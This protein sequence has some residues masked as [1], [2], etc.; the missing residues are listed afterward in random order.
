[1]ELNT[2]KQKRIDEFVKSAGNAGVLSWIEELKKQENTAEV[3]L[4]GGAVRDALCGFGSKDF[5][6]VVVGVSAKKLEKF[7]QKLGWVELLGKNFGVFKFVP[8]KLKGKIE[9]I[10]IALPRKEHVVVGSGAYKDFKV[11]SDHRLKI[12]DDLSRRD[13]TINAMA[14]RVVGEVYELIDNYDGLNDLE[15]KIIR[16]VGKAKD[17]FAEDYSRMLRAIRFSCQLGFEIESK[18]KKAIIKHIKDINKKSGSEYIIPRE[19]IAKEFIKALLESP[20]KA[21]DLFDELGVFTQLIPEIEA[22]KKCKQPK[23]YHTEGNVFVHTR[24]ALS[25]MSTKMYDN[26]FKKSTTGQ[27]VGYKDKVYDSDIV[28]AVLLHDIDKPTAFEWRVKKGKKKMTYYNHEEMGAKTAALICER[29]KLSSPDKI[30]CRCENV[31]WLIE[32]HMMLLED[33][34]ENMRQTK[35]EKYMLSDRYPGEKLLQ[36]TYADAVATVPA[37]EKI[38]TKK[39][40][41]KDW[42]SL[43]GFWP[44]LKRIKKIQNM[45]P[46]GN[47]A[48]AR[49]LNG[50]DVMKIRKIKSGSGVGRILDELREAQLREKVKTKKEAIEFIKKVKI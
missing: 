26:Q 21:Y 46:S 41:L 10:D 34:V 16:T 4:V 31:S 25:Q 47:K 23:N 17:R 43:R 50:N 1:M 36:V 13:F 32:K 2:K 48:P 9:P 28:L 37:G 35:F 45:N 29:L 49:L 15:D 22:M 3:Y 38:P 5:D 18:T 11:N 24:L 14:L 19:I 8:K 39:E 42:I 27:E 20:A 30:G 44:A 6:F 33:K 40:D 12:E 7:L